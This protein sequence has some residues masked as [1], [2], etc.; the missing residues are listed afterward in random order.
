MTT[1]RYTGLIK[2]KGWKVG[3]ALNHWGRS[4]DWYHRNCNGTDAQ[5]RR[6]TDMCKGLE[7]KGE[8]L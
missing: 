8:I 1:S 4:R 3:E 7:T 6:L 5:Q 2:I